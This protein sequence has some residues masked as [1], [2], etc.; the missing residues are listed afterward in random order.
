M[1]ACG[2]CIQRPKGMSVSGNFT[3]R[4]TNISFRNC[5]GHDGPGGGLAVL[6]G[7]LRQ[8][9]GKMR[10]DTCS[11]DAGGG[12]FV[13]KKVLVSDGMVFKNCTAWLAA[14]GGPDQRVKLRT[15]PHWFGC[16]RGGCQSRFKRPTFQ[17][18]TCV[19]RSCS[20]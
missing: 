13:Q 6:H 8:L 5:E 15:S 11:A 10:F 17:A 4:G 16:S 2:F 7:R 20:C 18:W 14:S 12:L 1:L 9:S 19:D 3:Q